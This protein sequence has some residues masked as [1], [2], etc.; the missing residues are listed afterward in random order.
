MNLRYRYRYG[1]RE[2]KIGIINSENRE[3]LQDL[4]SYIYILPTDTVFIVSKIKDSMSNARR[5]KPTYIRIR[6]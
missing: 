4:Y 6:Y 3:V 1:N 5:F 2:E